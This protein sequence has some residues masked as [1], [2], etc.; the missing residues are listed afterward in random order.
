MRTIHDCALEVLSLFR[1]NLSFTQEQ[2]RALASLQAAVENEGATDALASLKA[3][4]D[5]EI[6]ALNEVRE[7]LDYWHSGPFQNN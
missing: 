5:A 2:N 1:T 6:K 7:Q 4:V 3:T